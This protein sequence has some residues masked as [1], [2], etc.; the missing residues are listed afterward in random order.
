MMES[1]LKRIMRDHESQNRWIALV[2]CLSMLVS[3]GTF[4]TL[5]KTAVAQTYTKQI[6]DCPY[7]AE[8]AAS[9]A[10]KHNDDCRDENGNLVCTLPEREAHTHSEEC[11]TEIRTLACGLEENP[12][13]QHSD[14]CFETR[15]ELICGMNEGDGAHTHTDACF[16]TERELTCGMEEGEGAHTHT[17]SCYEVSRE[18]TCDKE[19]LSLHVHDANCIKTVELTKEEVEEKPQ[20][21]EDPE[22]TEK[23]EETVAPSGDEEDGLPEKPESDPYA[24]VE[25][26]ADWDAMFQN[27]DLTGNWAEDLIT[28]A[29]TQ[30]GYSE[31]SLNFEAYL[32]DD[33]DGYRLFGWTRYGAWYG[34]PYGDWC[35]MFISFCL[36]YAGISEED[37]PYDSGTINWAD[38]LAQLEMYHDSYGYTPK[39]GD[40]VF[41]DW[42]GITGRIMSVSSMK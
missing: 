38:H 16:V 25:S 14:S 29:E 21:T 13:H 9:V 33:Q 27:M 23:P 40:L 31:S 11:Y 15:R 7:A 6:L 3:L 10:H 19:E 2:L 17:D 24:D 36:H 20:A 22:E 41:F 4:A 32:N 26:A 35:V 5:H 8:G 34:Y 28:V 18:L 42:E 30:L 37:F 1:L 12:G 39:A